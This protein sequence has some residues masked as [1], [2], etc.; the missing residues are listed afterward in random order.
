MTDEPG[1]LYEVALT[2]RSYAF[3]QPAPG[4]H[5]ERLEL[6]GDAVLGLVVT[7]LI[8]RSYPDLSEGQLATLRA[9]VVNT[10]ALADVARSMELGELIRLGRG[11]DASG[12]RDK[13]SLLADTLEALIGAAYI[14]RGT[15]GVMA[16][17]APV[18]ADKIQSTVAQGTSFDAKGALQERVVRTGRDR[19]SYQTSSSGPDHSKQFVAEVFVAGRL[20]GAGTG[21]SKKEAEQNAARQALARLDARPAS[22]EEAVDA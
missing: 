1:G 6:L 8:F 15:E 12:G 13:D 21:R 16:A 9:S 11:E 18:F 22:A 4:V 5:N 19:P 7:D 14:E 3:E 17:L 2:H 10:A 20:V